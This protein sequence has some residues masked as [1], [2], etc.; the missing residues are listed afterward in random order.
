VVKPTAI[1]SMFAETLSDL[2]AV[3][4]GLI[5]SMPNDNLTTQCRPHEW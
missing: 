4:H 5:K 3:S 1:S 2:V